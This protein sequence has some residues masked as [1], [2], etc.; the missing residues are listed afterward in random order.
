MYHG[1]AHTV[2]NMLPYSGLASTLNKQ[3]K[4]Q[5]AHVAGREPT[6]FEE[7][8]MCGAMLGQFAQTLSYSPEVTRRKM[9]T[10][11]IV[12]TTGSK[13]AAFMVTQLKPPSTA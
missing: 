12:S 2:L 11:G 10:I 8:L 3:T 5:I 6:M 13:S 7:G 1:I 4:R 9:R